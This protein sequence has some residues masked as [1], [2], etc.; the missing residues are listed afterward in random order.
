MSWGGKR[1]GAGRKKGS[2]T[3]RTRKT[4]AIAEKAAGEGALPLEVMLRAMRDHFAAGRW[5]EAV[6]IAKDAAPYVHP[7]LGSVQTTVST[8]EPVRVVE[9]LVIRHAHLNRRREGAPCPWRSCSAPC[10]TYLPLLGK[11]LPIFFHLQVRFP[12]PPQ[13]IFRDDQP[14]QHLEV[15]GQLGVALQVGFDACPL[16]SL[17]AAF[18]IGMDEFPQHRQAASSGV[19]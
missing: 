13:L 15:L 1:A 3:R 12:A 2:G 9:E 8:T 7:R 5:E 18:Q 19:R 11:A 10:A 16:A 14:G 17:E 4:N 6:A